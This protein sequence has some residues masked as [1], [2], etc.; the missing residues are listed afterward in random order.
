MITTITHGI[1][2]DGLG[3][4]AIIKRYLILKKNIKSKEITLKYAHY[5]T[6]LGKMKKILDSDPL[7]KRIYITDIGFNDD[8]EKLFPDLKELEE[9]GCKIFWFDHHIIEPKVESKLKKIITEYTN[10]SGQ[11]TAEIVKRYFLPHDSVSHQIAEYA[12][13][14][15]FR[16]DKYHIAEKLQS[17]ISYNRGKKNYENRW[18]IVNYL[19]NGNFENQWFEEQYEDLRERKEKTMKKTLQNVEFFTL[20]HFGEFVISHA[21]EEGG[22]VCNYLKEKYPEIKTYIG[23]DERYN[24][25]IIYSSE[26]DCREIARE[27]GGG[28]H[29]NRAG[30]KYPELINPISTYDPDFMKR[31]FQ[32][33]LKYKF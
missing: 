17:I 16:T 25:V 19:V 1:D 10:N 23:I 26:V 30:F 32:L 15:D 11:C 33:L 2:L 31:L 21:K 14:I 29:K 12:S 28:G 13:D 27:F 4:Q 3:S 22:I 9:K 24:E 6:F 8:F 18:K 7:P 5:P 20:R